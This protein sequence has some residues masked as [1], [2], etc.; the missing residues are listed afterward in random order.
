MMAFRRVMP[1]TELWA[2]EMLGTCVDGQPVLLVN[3]DGKVSAFEDRCR[4]Q[5]V[6]LSQGKLAGCVL[7]CS[8]HEW[9][10]DV[11]TGCGINPATVRLVTFASKV[12]AG[13]IWV[14]V[15]ERLS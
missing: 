13:A 2:G 8:A 14:D 6:P 12:E 1:E 11:T 7:T 4:H 9:R 5:G 15:D 3:I 10:Y